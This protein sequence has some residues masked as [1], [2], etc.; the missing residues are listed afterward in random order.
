MEPGESH[1]EQA[2]V[3]ALEGSAIS[4]IASAYL[5]GSVVEGREHR[6]SDVDIAVLLDPR[7]AG[8]AR[9]RF[10]K[11][12]RLIEDLTVALSPRTADVVL[13]NDAPPLFARRIVT[14]GR[15]VYCPQRDTD[16]AFL[17]DTQLRAADLEP[18]LR[19]T[20]RVKLE[21]LAR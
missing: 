5:F 9:E 18:F 17:R 11:R 10:D 15:R 1:V 3:R 21:A 14:A 6:E 7:S 13:L 20:R 16:A 4:G 12:L 2:V 8:D 19:R